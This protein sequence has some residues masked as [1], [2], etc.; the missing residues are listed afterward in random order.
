MKT[1]LFFFFANI[2]QEKRFNFPTPKPFYLSKCE[3]KKKGGEGVFF[4]RNR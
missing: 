3:E 4:P 2:K 1:L